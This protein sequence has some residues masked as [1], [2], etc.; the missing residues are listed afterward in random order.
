VLDSSCRMS[1]RQLRKLQQQ[2]ELEKA[3]FNEQPE[4][5]EESEDEPVL[6]T[7]SKASL[8]AS[9][10]ALEDEDSENQLADDDE[11]DAD[12]GSNQVRATR[13]TSK[14]SKK[15][16]KKKTKSK[17]GKEKLEVEE[18][19]GFSEDI[20]AVLRE[21]DLKESA[22][23]LAKP[24]SKQVSKLP[25]DPEYTRVCALLSIGS[26]HL[27]VANEMRDMYGKDFSTADGTEDNGQ[28]ARGGRRRQQAGQQVDIG[29][30][31]KGR[32]LPGK[33]LSA[34]TIRRNALIEGKQDWPNSNTGG[35]AMEIVDDKADDETVEFRFTH[36]SS[37]QANQEDFYDIVE[38]GNPEILVTFLLK[39]RKLLR[40]CLTYDH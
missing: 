34:I 22:Q 9:L 36:D 17:K 29:T 38:A 24:T 13:S 16:K 15:S 14:K 5:E 23:A 4:T 39:N 27:K 6:P 30:A 1:S 31:L 10:A 12:E 32:H 3:K 20:D 40:L 28:G 18:N 25:V 11:D 26:K 21:L 35:L 37:Y 19:A 33:G 7:K 2:R 8:F